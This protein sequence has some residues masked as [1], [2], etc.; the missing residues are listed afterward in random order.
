[1]GFEMK[2]PSSMCRRFDRR[3]SLARFYA[4]DEDP[5]QAFDKICQLVHCNLDSKECYQSSVKRIA[6]QSNLKLLRTTLT[7]TVPN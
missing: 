2:I 1:M 4:G 5:L 3:W 7:P 6:A